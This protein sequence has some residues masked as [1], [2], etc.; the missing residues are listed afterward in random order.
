MC[1]VIFLVLSSFIC[2]FDFREHLSIKLHTFVSQLEKKYNL[3]TVGLGGRVNSSIG[4]T[5]LYFI[6]MDKLNLAT[7]RKRYV[8]ICETYLN[9]INQDIKLRPFLKN[10]PFGIHN[11][12]FTI[13]DHCFYKQNLELLQKQELFLN[14][15]VCIKGIVYYSARD[16]QGNLLTVYQE[17]YEEALRIVKEQREQGSGI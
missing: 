6:T 1:M 2:L 13:S 8:D 7:A 10:F 9:L 17:P 4:E 11:I 16:D 14:H 5:S 12:E 15:V 3:Q